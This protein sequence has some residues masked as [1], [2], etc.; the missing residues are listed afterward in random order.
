MYKQGCKETESETQ[1]TRE[2]SKV[3]NWEVD[4]GVGYRAR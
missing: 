4:I 2:N 3:G 1:K